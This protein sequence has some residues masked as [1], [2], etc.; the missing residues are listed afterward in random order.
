MAN[1]EV[2]EREVQHALNIEQVKEQYYQVVDTTENIRDGYV[3][4][5]LTNGSKSY[6]RVVE[7]KDEITPV[8]TVSI[9]KKKRNIKTKLLVHMK[10]SYL[11][12]S[13][14]TI[15]KQ[16]TVSIRDKRFLNKQI[17]EVRKEIKKYQSLLNILS[18]V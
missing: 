1:S 17:I 4:E 6:D 9:R 3:I 14:F 7:N 12:L 2:S 18:T 10:R 11:D 5:H 15:A 13:V 16:T 8:T